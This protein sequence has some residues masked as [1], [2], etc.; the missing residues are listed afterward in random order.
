MEKESNNEL[1][2]WGIKGQKWGVRRY[3]NKDGSLTP[4]GKKR[5]ESPDI[6]EF[7]YG[8]SKK[9]NKDT[10]GNKGGSG[11]NPPPKKPYKT[12]TVDVYKKV[13]DV[14]KGPSGKKPYKAPKADIEDIASVKTDT[15]NAIRNKLVAEKNLKNEIDSYK[16]DA[17]L[18]RE[19]QE[20]ASAKRLNKV[21]KA[22]EI[23]SKVGN[24]I[25][26]EGKSIASSI[27]KYKNAKEM[28]DYKSMSDAELK[29]K[30]NR[31]IAENNYVRESMARTTAASHKVESVLSAIGSALV[32]TGSG[33]AVY[34]MIKELKE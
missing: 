5:Y 11:D 12:P 17:Q 33:L 6:T 20:Q 1:K 16:T 25:G 30:T 27:R 15:L 31:I 10:S 22:G 9:T 7:Y 28:E 24:S 26:N 23:T 8:P 14:V 3:Q 19:A 29:A 13:D 32:V 4:A 2:H 34:K 18:R 21:G